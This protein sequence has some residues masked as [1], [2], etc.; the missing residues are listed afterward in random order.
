MLDCNAIG[1]TL[2]LGEA[3]PTIFCVCVCVECLEHP[4]AASEIN[5]YFNGR[6]PCLPL[7]PRLDTHTA[8]YGLV[9]VHSERSTNELKA[10]THGFVDYGYD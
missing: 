6:N 8:K 9:H 10:K 4:M 7:L 5:A 2:A 1:N 3:V